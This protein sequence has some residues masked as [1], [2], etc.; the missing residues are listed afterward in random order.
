M[1]R[2]RGT[3]GLEISA[4]EPELDELTG[5]FCPERLNVSG[6]FTALL[7]RMLGGFRWTNPSIAEIILTA[8]NCVMARREGDIGANEFIGSLDDLK[9]NLRG[10]VDVVGLNPEERIRLAFIIGQNVT[11]GRANFDPFEVISA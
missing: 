6:M 1:I 10:V 3:E 4:V 2:L 7:A 9:R 11:V 5:K 8:D